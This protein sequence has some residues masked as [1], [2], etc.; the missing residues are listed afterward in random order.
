MLEAFRRKYL[1]FV[2]VVS[3]VRFCIY[4][5]IRF[6]FRKSMSKRQTNYTVDE[7]EVIVSGVEKNSKVRDVQI[8]S[9]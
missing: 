9:Q 4:L 6:Y 2:Y 7:I 5:F 1:L 8:F 3:I